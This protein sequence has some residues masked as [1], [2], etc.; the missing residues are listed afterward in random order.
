[1]FRGISHISIDTKGR[2][3]IPAKYRDAFEKTAAEQIV[4]TIDHTDRCLLIYPMDQWLI[5]EKM[6][7]ALPNTDRRVRT[8]QRMILGHAADVELDTQGR[9]LLPAPLREYAGLNKQ[10]VLVGQMNKFE[11]WDAGTWERERDTWLAQA[12]DS[13]ETNAILSQVCL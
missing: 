13:D 1:M 9:I 6:L 7:S 8:M 3:A 10:V 4:V 11:L 5:V 12:K 2:L